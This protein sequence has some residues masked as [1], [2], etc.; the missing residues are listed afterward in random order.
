MCKVKVFN[1]V[2]KSSML[3]LL[4]LLIKFNILLFF[5]HDILLQILNT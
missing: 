1:Y 3:F 4:N 2:I 5:F